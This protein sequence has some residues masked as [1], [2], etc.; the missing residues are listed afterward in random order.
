MS[1]TYYKC[2]D[3]GFEFDEPVVER[4]LEHHGDHYYEP[5]AEDHCPKCNGTMIEDGERCDIC[6]DNWAESGSYGAFC[7]EC[8]SEATHSVEALQNAMST[9]WTTAVGLFVEWA[10]RNW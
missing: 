8:L 1:G 7:S 6:G 5:M 2:K 9:D 4:W 3:C 10:E